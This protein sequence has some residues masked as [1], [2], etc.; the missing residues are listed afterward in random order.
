MQVNV[1]DG[2]P[3]VLNSLLYKPPDQNLINYMQ[4]KFHNI[5]HG[6]YNLANNFKNS[7]SK[8]YNSYYNNDVV[9]RHK[10]LAAHA[11]YVLREDVIHHVNYGEFDQANLLTQRYIMAYPELNNRMHRNLCHG[12]ADTYFDEYPDTYGKDRPDYQ[13]VMDGVLQINTDDIAYVNHYTNANEADSL[14]TMEKLTILDIW[15][16][17]ARMLADDLDPTDV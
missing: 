1:I 13:S 2:G 10:Q 7:I 16:N 3:E 5:L 8:L 9:N 12:F 11:S 15:D 4:N 6:T 17:A 14:T